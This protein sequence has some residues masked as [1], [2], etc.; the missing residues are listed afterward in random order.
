[1]A[2]AHTHEG[3]RRLSLLFEAGP[4]RYAIEATRV[5]EVAPPDTD[6]PTVRGVF[7]LEDLSMLMGGAPERRPGLALVLDTSP[8]RAVRVREGAEVA[9][10]SGDPHFQLTRDLAARIGEVVRGSLLHAGRLY[11]ELRAEA[12]GQTP[13]LP[14]PPPRIVTWLDAAA[15]PML[16]FESG[17][18]LFAIPLGNVLQVV[19]VGTA[20]C[21]FPVPGGVIAGVLA[22]GHALWPVYGLSAFFGGTLAVESH[23]VLAELAGMQVA[24]CASRV[25]GVESRLTP[26]GD[27]GTWKT[28]S[29][30]RALAPDVTR[31]LSA[32]NLTGPSGR[33]SDDTTLFKGS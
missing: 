32:S 6:R 3:G 8:T 28:P 16:L 21:P 11:L 18:R 17:E 5:V 23:V 13:V 14:A 12:L 33:P 30:A 22:H 26:E 15:A 7:P 20:F 10:V 31:L 27:P 9:D 1:V 25:L 19:P 29:G 2:A 4:A 24:L